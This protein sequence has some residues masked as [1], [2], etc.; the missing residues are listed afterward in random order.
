[1][2]VTYYQNFN[3]FR[4]PDWRNNRV[5]EMVSQLGLPGRLKKTDDYYIRN[6]RKFML[7]YNS[8]LTDS[9][10]E[11]LFRREPSL[12]YAHD[13]WLKRETIPGPSH[14][15][16][17]RLLAGQSYEEIAELWGTMPKTIEWYE[18]LFFDVKDH[19]HKRDWI[20]TQILIPKLEYYYGPEEF[21]PLGNTNQGNSRSVSRPF[22]DASLKFFGYFGGPKLLDIILYGFNPNKP[23][24]DGD[25]FNEWLDDQWKLT[26]RKRSVQAALQFK[27]NKFNVMEL[28]ET[29]AK[30]IS[31]DQAANTLTSPK[32]SYEK[33]IETLLNDLPFSIGDSSKKIYSQSKIEVYDRSSSE[34]RD[35]E[36]VDIENGREVKREL[37]GS[38]PEPKVKES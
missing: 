1:M 35:S 4:V 21:S 25:Q 34:L 5:L 32:T 36:L 12:Y 28:F 3:I 14:V 33:H 29:H 31:L 37:M 26:L 23:L 16:E 30:I 27:V 15:I 24:E 19:L 38:F 11:L 6:Y 18:K 10:K 8:R 22:L 9:Q 2:N 7:L 20:T 17:A 13:L